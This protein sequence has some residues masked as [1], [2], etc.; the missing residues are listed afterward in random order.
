MLVSK[1]ASLK[2]FDPNN[3]LTFYDI[4]DSIE[5]KM[6][7]KSHNKTYKILLNDFY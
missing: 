2:G 5:E 3:R 6:F 4:T 7:G 1:K